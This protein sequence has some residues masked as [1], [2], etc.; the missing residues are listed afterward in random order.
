MAAALLAVL[1]FALRDGLTIV[2]AAAGL[3][4]AGFVWWVRRSRS[5]ALAVLSL[6]VACVVTSEVARAA[7]EASKGA[8]PLGLGVVFWLFLAVV[9][10]TGWVATRERPGRRLLTVVAGHLTLVVASLL[11]YF[12]V[13]VVPVAGLLAAMA[14]VLVVCRWRYAPADTTPDQRGSADRTANLARGAD[15]TRAGLETALDDEWL[16]LSGLDLPGGA[17]VEHLAVGPAGVFVVESRAWPG[18]LGLVSV[19]RDGKAVEAYGLDG[20]VRELAARLE[21]VLRTVTAAADLPWL[22]GVDVYAVVALWGEA[23]PERPVDV[24]LRDPRRPGR[25]VAVRL[26]SG[27]EVGAWMRSRPRTLGGKSLSR[28]LARVE[29]H[30]PGGRSSVS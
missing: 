10:V 25:G 21:P 24:E 27:A 23:V 11:S 5:G 28:V 13:T 7:A 15:R 8:S 17:T 3:V 29:R 9:T 30:V 22:A 16:V 19:Q 20:D 2:L 14:V 4:A 26:V 12:S 6:C 1:V 18:R